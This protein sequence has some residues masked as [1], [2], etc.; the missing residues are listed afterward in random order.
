MHVYSVHKVSLHLLTFLLLRLL[1]LEGGRKRQGAVGN[2]QA[3][4]GL[5]LRN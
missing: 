4:H 1:I 2:L 3:G 5:I